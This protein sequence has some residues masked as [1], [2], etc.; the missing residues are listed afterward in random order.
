MSQHLSELGSGKPID[1]WGTYA[2][3][4]YQRVISIQALTRLPSN[5]VILSNSHFGFRLKV[6]LRTR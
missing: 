2:V 5:F 6:G 4:F 3:S 1:E